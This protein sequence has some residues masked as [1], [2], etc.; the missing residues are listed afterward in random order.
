MSKNL[1]ITNVGGTLNDVNGTKKMLSSD[2]HFVKCAY[3]GNRNCNPTCAA[4][5]IRGQKVVCIRGGVDTEFEIGYT[6]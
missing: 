6:S 5:I 3:D 1:Q 4:C 2:G